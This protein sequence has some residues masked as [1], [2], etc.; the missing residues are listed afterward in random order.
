MRFSPGLRIGCIGFLVLAVRSPLH[1]SLPPSFA[2]SS[3]CQ[4]SGPNGHPS[5]IGPNMDSKA[6]TCGER[7]G[8]AVSFAYF[9]LFFLRRMNKLS[10]LNG[11][12]GVWTHPLT[13]VKLIRKN[14]IGFLE[15]RLCRFFEIDEYQRKKQLYCT[16][17]PWVKTYGPFFGQCPSN[18]VYFG[19]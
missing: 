7:Q 16:M 8:R 6:V 19:W 3:R 18:L 14:A 13:I 15:L 1:P 5:F 4:Q 2:P 11:K 17:W 10:V 12:N 9:V